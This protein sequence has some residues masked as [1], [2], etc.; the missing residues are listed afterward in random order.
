MSTIFACSTGSGR[1][2]IAIWR[3]SGP[4]ARTVLGKLV[5]EIP[6][7]RYAA[8]RQLRDPGGGVLDDGIVLWF[9]GPNS[10]TGEDLAELQIHGSQAVASRLTAILS[11]MGLNPAEPGE[12]TLRALRNGRMGLLEAEGLGDLLDAETEEQRQQALEG[13]QGSGR[14]LAEEWRDGLTSALGLL[15]AGVDFPDEEDIPEEISARALPVLQDIRDSLDAAIREG[16]SGRRLREG[17]SLAIVGPPNAGKSTLLN[18]LLGEERAIVSEIPG[19][20]RDVVSARLDIA[21]RLV[22]V[23]DTAGLRESTDDPIERAGMER[24]RAAA[25]EADLVIAVTPAGAPETDSGEW[26]VAKVLKIT[27][28]S[29][30]SSVGSEETLRLSAKTGE[31][32]DA[33]LAEL[34]EKVR[35]AAS[36]SLFPHERQ[37]ALLRAGRSALD[38]VLDDPARDPELLAEDVR[39]VIRLLDQITGRV[40]TED[41]LGAIFSRFC[42]GK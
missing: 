25:A 12:F 26:P 6:S 30:L 24:S 27:S 5:G 18:R 21:G 11:G 35:G 40:T 10:A 22:E 19:T 23:L 1:T 17:L 31:G 34:A 16:D 15:E 39:S 41:V 37:L 32:W 4:E 33:F 29:D 3:I 28:K 38:Q 13:Y 42:V 8:Y 20:T 7:A 2:A 14:A 9:P 36:P